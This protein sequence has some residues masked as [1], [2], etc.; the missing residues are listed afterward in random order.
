MTFNGKLCHDSN[1]PWNAELEPIIRT[2]ALVTSLSPLTQTSQAL[3]LS[4]DPRCSLLVSQ[5]EPAEETCNHV[6]MQ[7]K[8]RVTRLNQLGYYIA[9]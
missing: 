6:R 3:G 9:L 2:Q 8:S 1:S 5:P 7:R 4:G